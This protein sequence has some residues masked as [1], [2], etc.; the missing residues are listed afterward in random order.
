MVER[1]QRVLLFDEDNIEREKLREV[2]E[3]IAFV[4]AT[5]ILLLTFAIALMVFSIFAV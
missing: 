5:A 1:P 3:R 4:I 2:Q